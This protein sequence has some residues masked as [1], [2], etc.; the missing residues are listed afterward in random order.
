MIKKI[1][2]LFFISQNLKEI[3]KILLKQRPIE[4]KPKK[5]NKKNKKW[6]KF[7]ILKTALKL[8]Q[9]KIMINL[10]IMI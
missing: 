4:N 5:D 2:I 1:K 9:N 6:A 10:K 8:N 3:T 7:K